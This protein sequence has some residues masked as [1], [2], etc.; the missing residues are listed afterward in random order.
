MHQRFQVIRGKQP[1]EGAEEHLRLRE[2]STF[3]DA[4]LK[5]LDS[6][7]GFALRLT[8]GHRAAAEDLVQETSLRAFRSFDGLRS[9]TKIKSWLFR[10]LVNTRI[11]EFHRRARE[12][13]IVDI[14][15]SESLLESAG[16]KQT[17]T[18]E[19]NL[20]EQLL[21]DEIQ[22]ALDWLP[23]EFRT[24]VWLSDVEEL[25]YREIGEVIGC[26]LGTVASRLYRGH[27]LL[28]ERLQE[29]GRRRGFIK[30]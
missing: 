14:E 8:S 27:G 17:S 28:R 15:L 2:H 19:Q 29:F 20:F 23:V 21:D 5:H 26:P 9:P 4:L 25:S 11:N 12:A 16:T 6:L 1:A 24:V 3:E 13:P 18:P 10:I 30:E 7:L 22:E